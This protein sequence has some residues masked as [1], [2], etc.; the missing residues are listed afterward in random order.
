MAVL[1]VPLLS[2]LRADVGSLEQVRRLWQAEAGGG[3]GI[4]GW[5]SC[6]ECQFP[7]LPKMGW[8]M[9][10]PHPHFLGKGASGKGGVGL[11]QG[12]ASADWL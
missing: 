10:F 9:V 12:R 4:S 5:W 7:A 11:W 3:G 1:E 6:P 2:G 8:L